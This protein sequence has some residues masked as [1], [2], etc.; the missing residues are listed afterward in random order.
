MNK[1]TFLLTILLLL[2]SSFTANAALNMGGK[3]IFTGTLIEVL[4]PGSAT[5]IQDIIDNI[6][7]ASVAKPYLI[8]LGA[9][10]YNLG[11]TKIVMKEWVSIQGSGQEATKITGAVTVNGTLMGANNASLMDL[12]IENTG[13]GTTS[14]AIFNSNAS[15]RIERVT[16][17]ASGGTSNTYGVYNLGTSSPVMTNVT[18]TASAGAGNNTGVRNNNSS[19]AMTNV[20]ASAS[21]VNIS[22]GIFNDTSS[23][24]MTNVTASASGGTSSYGIFN[25]SSSSPVMTNVTASGSGGTS[26]YGI[27]NVGVS[28][29]FIQD[30]TMEG[31]TKGLRIN[32]DSPGTRVVNSKIIGGVN[33]Q[34]SGT[35]QCRGNYDADLNP[36]TC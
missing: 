27:H 33:D 23:P 10:V 4:E 6:I 25:L 15:P 19:P 31:D 11:A 7:D 18:A 24:V 1:I 36:V 13:G 9:G 8:H 22:Y 30:S 26:S 20:T 12:T 34:P 35:T 21:G 32:S 3:T 5:Q 28:T 29:A 16:S 2:M 14:T 17:T